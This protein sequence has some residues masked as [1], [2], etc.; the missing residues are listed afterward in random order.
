MTVIA[1]DFVPIVPYN[2]TNLFIGIGQRYDVIITADQSP[3]AY[4]F[5]ADVQDTAG[6]GTNFNNGNIR[7]VFAYSGHESETPTSTEVSYNARCTDET[8]LVPFWDSFV[9]QGQTGTFTELT[10]AQLQQQENDGSITLYWLVNGTTLIADWEQ[11]TLEYIRTGNTS[12]PATANVL[13]L[14]NENVWTYWVIQEVPGNPYNVSVPHPMR[15]CNLPSHKH[16]RPS[17][18]DSSLTLPVR[19]P[20]P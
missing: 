14:P 13:S 16:T 6:C 11:P 4:W 19:S 9:P 10:T 5:R 15:K 17:F 20:R 8:G 1:A 7:S 12:Y 3:G 18:F 2:T